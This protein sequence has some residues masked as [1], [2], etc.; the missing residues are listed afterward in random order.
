MKRHRGILSLLTLSLAFGLLPVAAADAAGSRLTIYNGIRNVDVISVKVRG[1]KVTGFKRLKPG[2]G[3][4]I[5]ASSGDGKCAAWLVARVED[6]NAANAL[7][8][9]CSGGRFVVRVTPGN[10]DGRTGGPNDL[11]ID[12]LK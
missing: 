3:I 7:I 8:D 5:N 10:P 11:G 1:G 9:V 6:G 2:Q 4:K 12:V